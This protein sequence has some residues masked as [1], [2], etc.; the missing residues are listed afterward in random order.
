PEKFVLDRRRNRTGTNQHRR[1]V[2]RRPSPRG[3]NVAA[4][5]DHRNGRLIG[6]LESFNEL[7]ASFV[8]LG[9]F[10][11]DAL[12]QADPFPDLALA[13]LLLWLAFEQL[14]LV[15][16]QVGKAALLLDVGAEPS[17]Q[18][19]VISKQGL[20][21]LALELGNMVVRVVQRGLRGLEPGLCRFLACHQAASCSGSGRVTMRPGCPSAAASICSA[22]NCRPE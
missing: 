7:G 11:L 3:S 9:E 1:H 6:R 13:L 15:S 4:N 22:L 19:I 17:G 20:P 8:A 16:V 14:D 12:D 21:P 18:A 5:I 10:C 2:M